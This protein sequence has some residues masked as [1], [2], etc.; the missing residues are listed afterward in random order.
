MPG[1]SKMMSLAPLATAGAAAADAKNMNGKYGVSSGGD[2]LTDWN[3][4]YAAKGYEFFDVWAPEIA[5]HYGQVFWTDQGTTPLPPD[6]VKRFEGKVIAIQGYEQ[7]QVIVTPLGSPGK[8][9]DQDVSVP[10]N[11]AYNHHYCAWMGGKHSERKE[12]AT[13]ADHYGS[14]AHGQAFIN[15]TVDKEDQSGRLFPDTAQTK[16]FI[17]E[18]NGGESRKSFHGYPEGFAQLIESPQNW[19]ITPMQIDTRNRVHGVTAADVKK[20]TNFSGV[21]ENGKPCAGYEPRQARY[22]RNWAG[23]DKSPAD[24]GHYS[25]ILECPCNGRFGGAPEFYPTQ[26]TKVMARS[27]TAIPSGTCG[28]GK[29][30][31]GAQACFDA[32]AGLGFNATSIAN[33]TETDP[34]QPA[35]CVL[36]KNA[37]GSADALFNKGGSGS[38]TAS[39]VKEAGS[40]SAVTGVTVGISLRNTGLDSEG[41]EAPAAN[42]TATITLTGPAD[43]WFAVGLHAK[44]MA[45]QPYTLVV[46][47]SGVTERK[48]ATCGTEA[49]H[50]AGT[51][52][53]SSVKLV[54]NTVTNGQRTVVS[55]FRHRSSVLARSR[56]DPSKPAYCPPLL[57]RT[58]TLRCI[59]HRSS[60]GRLP[61][62]PKTTS[63]SRHR[64]RL[65][66]TSRR[67]E[68]QRARTSSPITASRARTP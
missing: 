19:H 32:I 29:E 41:P 51:P 9:P 64:T 38:C 5:T 59:C 18:G 11:W 1:L 30:F 47:A 35:G 46:N 24:P 23:V 45:D 62:Q 21:G 65:C 60:R 17:S 39:K 61:A 42:G 6:I 25:G 31:K 13:P 54:S 53:A 44:I 2:V 55:N 58:L 4:D 63:R 7:D 68:P 67:T 48:L 66:R 8:N 28:N 14:G 34:K 50:C 16:W 52:L 56:Q 33:K 3:S 22:G 15:A 20:C 49:D 36:I 37:D 26:K 27:I 10:I 40:T 57:P 12:I 43:R